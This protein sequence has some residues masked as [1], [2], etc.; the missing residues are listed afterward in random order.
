MLCSVIASTSSV[1]RRHDVD[2]PFRLGEA[3]GA[4]AGRT[5]STTRRN[6]APSRK[7]TS[8]GTHF[9]PPYP[10]CSAIS[11][12][13]CSR[14]QKLAASITPAARPSEPSM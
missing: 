7:P 6:S 11:I 1:A 10:S 14:L 2:G 8:G 4:G 9:R 5:K 12:D 3:R 13:G